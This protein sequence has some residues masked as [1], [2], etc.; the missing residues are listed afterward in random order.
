MRPTEGTTRYLSVSWTRLRVGAVSTRIRTP[1]RGSTGSS[2]R[3]GWATC[4]LD[5]SSLPPLYSFPSTVY[6]GIL[7]SCPL[8]SKCQRNGN[9]Q[10]TSGELHPS[11]VA[12]HTMRSALTL[13]IRFKLGNSI[14]MWVVYQAIRRFSFI[15]KTPSM[16]PTPPITFPFPRSRLLTLVASETSRVLAHRLHHPLRR[17]SWSLTPE[18][19]WRSYRE[20][21]PGGTLLMYVPLFSL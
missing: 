12:S 19:S 16:P 8:S 21:S 9:P 18:I 4:E 1:N 11:F 6:F 13:G 10:T 14:S 5:A 7:S 15:H 3:A 17:V 20:H 2:A